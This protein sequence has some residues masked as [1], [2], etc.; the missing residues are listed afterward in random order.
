MDNAVSPSRALCR[1]VVVMGKVQGENQSSR[2]CVVARL[3]SRFGNEKAPVG[4]GRFVRSDSGRSVVSGM[5]IYICIQICI[6][7]II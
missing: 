6:Q 7:K 2:C 1:S 3:V 4:F 5:I